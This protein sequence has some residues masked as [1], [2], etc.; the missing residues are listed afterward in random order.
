MEVGALGSILENAGIAFE[1]RNEF[2]NANY[3][4]GPFDPELWILHEQDF[5]RAVQL[6]EAWRSAPR[7]VE[8]PWTCPKCGEQLEAQFS[9]C[10]SC[11]TGR[12]EVIK[13]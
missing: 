2:T 9:S 6:R 1:I 8:G 10:W 12:P 3:P 5:D 13:G 4:T 7:A 11:G